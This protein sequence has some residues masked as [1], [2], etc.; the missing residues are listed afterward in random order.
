ME[1]LLENHKIC[2][3]DNFADTWP[4]WNELVG[5]AKHIVATTNSSSM[6]MRM[7][8]DG[9]GIALHPVGIGQKEKGLIYLDELNFKVSHPFWLVSRTKAKDLPKVRALIDHFKKQSSQL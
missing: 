6:L 8:L 2:N 4:E 9:I 7:T 1:D 5:K 3:R